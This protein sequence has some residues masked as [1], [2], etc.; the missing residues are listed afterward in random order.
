VLLTV[1][2]IGPVLDLFSVER[3]EWG[4]TEVAERL[5]VAKSSAHA[6]LA[7][8][9]EV[10]LLSCTAQSR[11]R[12]GWRFLDLGETLKASLDLRGTALPFMRALVDQ[13]RETVQLAVLDRGHVL[14][15]ER[16]EGTHPVRFAG[17]PVGARW[18]SHASASGKVLLAVRPRGEVARIATVEGLRAMTARTITD[19]DRLHAELDDVRRLGYG[20]DVE[21]SVPGVSGVAAAIRLE[22][23]MSVAALSIAIPTSRFRDHE[24]LLRGAV[25]EAAAAVSRALEPYRVRSRAVSASSTSQRSVSIATP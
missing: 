4:V 10:G 13:H 1:K 17:A 25:V 21:E 23:G 12:L 7:S 2:K 6:L 5:S 16:L 15:V 19:L 18:P 24:P 9:A 22:Q 8:L 20:I 14:Y 11:Y 3:P